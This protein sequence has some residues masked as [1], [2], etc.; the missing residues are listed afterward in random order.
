MEFGLR[1]SG[2][3]VVGNGT[4]VGPPPRNG[5]VMFLK[6]NYIGKRS[7]SSMRFEVLDAKCLHLKFVGK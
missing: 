5:S 6:I 3:P 4:A 1:S 2:L 7:V